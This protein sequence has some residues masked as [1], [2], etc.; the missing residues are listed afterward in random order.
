MWFLGF[1]FL[2]GQMKAYPPHRGE[3]ARWVLGAL[4]E[5]FLFHR[6]WISI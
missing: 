1:G 6:P 4:G 3:G 5:N 2:G